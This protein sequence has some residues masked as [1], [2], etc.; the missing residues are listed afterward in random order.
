MT[1]VA[2]HEFMKP[3]WLIDYINHMDFV[4]ISSWILKLCLKKID[5]SEKMAQ[6]L[7]P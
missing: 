3:P 6:T 4:R 2:I 1:W 5:P 7:Q